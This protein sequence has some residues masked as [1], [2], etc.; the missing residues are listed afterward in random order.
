MDCRTAQRFLEVCRPTGDDLADTELASA[1]AHLEGCPDC[2]NHFRSRQAFDARVAATM[3]AVPVPAGLRDRIHSRLDHV[4]SRRRVLRMAV[5]S[6]AAAAAVL[7]AVGIFFWPGRPAE[8]TELEV[9]HLGEWATLE[10]FEFDAAGELSASLPDAKAVECSKQ[11]RRLKL[12]AELPAKWPLDS[13]IA[14]G[15]TKIYGRWVAVFRHHDPRGESDVLAFPRSDFLITNLGKGTEVVHPTR[16]LVV[17]AWAEENTTY[18]AVLKDWAP[19]D[20]KP[21]VGRSGGLM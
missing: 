8:P 5:W 18:V 10:N 14:V 15:R 11:L 4:A 16:N 9:H 1:T 6:G 12:N 19:E 2:L 13:L 7:L 3:Q 20:L 17:I 21:L